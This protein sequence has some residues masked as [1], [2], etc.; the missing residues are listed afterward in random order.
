MSKIYLQEIKRSYDTVIG[1][2]SA[3]DP[4]IHIKRLNLRKCSLPL[5][6]VVSLSLSDVSRLLNNKFRGFMELKNMQ[7]K[8]GS[9]FY[10]DDGTPV[11][12]DDRFTKVESYFV[13]DICYN[14]LSVHDFPILPNQDWTTTYPSFKEKLN[15]RINRFLDLMNTSQS[16]LFVRWSATYKEAIELQSALRKLTNGLFHV[17]IINPIEGL[18]HVVEMNWRLDRVCSIQ[19]PNRIHDITIWDHV[20]NGVTLTP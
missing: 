8:D 19:V 14:I 4:T 2:G 5:D 9:H 3:C 6:W 11:F 17:V 13:E 15:N 1:I 20:L 12:S 10:L 16:I 18:P 7:L